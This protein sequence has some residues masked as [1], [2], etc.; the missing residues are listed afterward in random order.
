MRGRGR[1]P[2]RSGSSRMTGRSVFQQHFW[3]CLLC[4]L[5]IL[6]D[7]TRADE[8][9][10]NIFKKSSWRFPSPSTHTRPP[11]GWSPNTPTGSPK[12]GKGPCATD[13]K[14]KKSCKDEEEGGFPSPF[15][16]WWEKYPT[17]APQRGPTVSPTRGTVRLPSAQPTNG[18]TRTTSNQTPVPSQTTADQT[19]VP[20]LTTSQTPAPGQTT[21]SPVSVEPPDGTTPPTRVDEPSVPT[22]DTLPPTPPPFT[23]A[24]TVTW[25]PTTSPVPTRTRFPTLS[26]WPTAS[27]YPTT[28]PWPTTAT[29]A[30]NSSQD[31]TA[32]VPPDGSRAPTLTNSPT[33]APPND[34]QTSNPTQAGPLVPTSTDAPSALTV[35]TPSPTSTNQQAGQMT[36]RPTARLPGC[37]ISN[38]NFGSSLGTPTEVSFG[39]EVETNPAL[40]GGTVSTQV[41]PPLEDAMVAYLLPALFPNTCSLS[42]NEVTEETEDTRTGAIG[43]NASPRDRIA[44]SVPCGELDVATNNCAFV[45]GGLTFSFLEERGLESR[46]ATINLILER[47]EFGMDNDIFLAAHPSIV[48]VTFI[49]GVGG[50]NPSPPEDDADRGINVEGTNDDDDDSLPWWPWLLIGGIFVPLCCG[51]AAYQ[52]NNNTRQDEDADYQ[53]VEGND[54]SALGE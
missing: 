18:P 29:E 10:E 15:D 31:T 28:S 20:S 23:V 5:V 2:S 52:R 37:R 32:P 42:E 33:A 19:S 17:I 45:D 3:G 7:P 27:G 14:G 11:V 43:V 1:R 49:V 25:E 16:P 48:R 4:A 26:P 13:K 54:N 53:A 30:P 6:G 9:E 36:S 21:A 35:L 46:Q 22:V 40:Q 38:G 39:Y 51:I 12:S 44:P 24:P 34:V 47:L 41:L 50:E 8:G